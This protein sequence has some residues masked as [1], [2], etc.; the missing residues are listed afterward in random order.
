M[1]LCEVTYTALRYYTGR[2]ATFRIDQADG[3]QGCPEG[4]SAL[5]VSLVALRERDG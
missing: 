1:T 3:G 2:Q 4:D 5:A